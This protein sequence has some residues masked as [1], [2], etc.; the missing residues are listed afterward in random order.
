MTNVNFFMKDTN[1]KAS[2][3]PL[4]DNYLS[5]NEAW[6]G[7]RYNV[8]GWTFNLRGDVFDN[9]NLYSPTQAMSNFGVG[10]WSVTK[11]VEGLTLT[12]G[13]IYDQI[14]CGVLF[15]SYEDRGLL[16][17]NALV[18]LELKYKLAKNVK[19][20]AFSGQ[21]KFLFERYG[22]IIKGL[23]LEA[24]LKAGKA[25]FSSGF[26]ILNRTI[27]QASMNNIVSNINQQDL[28]TRFDP[29]YNMY[30]FTLYNTLNYKTITW[31][32]EGAYKTNEA[33]RDG[34]LRDKTG[35]FQYTSLSY[36]KK[37]FSLNFSGKRTD[38]F[39]MRTSPNEILNNGML[40]WQPVVAAIRPERLMSRYTPPSQDIS[41]MAGCGQMLL[42]PSDVT[43]YNLSYT[44]INTLNGV[45]LFR[46]G[47][48]EVNYQGM[49]Q[50]VFQGG[51]QY[52]EYNQELYQVK[53]G[54]PIVKAITPFG[55]VTYRLT[56]A[57]SIRFE[58]QYMN[59]KQDYGSWVFGLLEY[60]LAPKFSI[61]ISDMYNVTPN[62]NNP[63]VTKANHYYS[64]YSAFTKGPHRL[65][66]AYVK[67]V[68]GINCTGG[69]CRYEPA[70]SGVKCTLTTS[71]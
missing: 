38:Y 29:K 23:N 58:A 17:D 43:N 59:T 31:Y 9:S 15:R 48:A 62:Y 52:M 19:V 26:G 28:K 3:N 68:D 5:G 44:H 2:G 20:K 51:I 4:Y 47:Y 30:A 71:F 56:D 24:D 16:I 69:V 25:R 46:E 50:W 13:S 18:G 36:A 8:K 53:P 39:V 12:V 33:I 35:N 37:G 14:G 27:D 22:P 57:K 55:E 45:E 42:S 40:N 54:V 64:L 41:E 63:L 21:Q 61:S 1:I 67:Q 32:L 10:A 11:E 49:K 6:L 66:L 7:L 34:I 70:F 65:S 60:N